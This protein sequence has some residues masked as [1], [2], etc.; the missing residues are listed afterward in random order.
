M[1][2]AAAAV[3]AL[4]VVA[5]SPAAGWAS[6]LEVRL[7]GFA[8]RAHSDLFTDDADLYT[9]DFRN[10]DCTATTCP[11]VRTRDWRGLYGGA[12]FSFNLD[13]HV[14]LGFSVDGYGRRIPTNYRTSVRDDG[15]EIQQDLRLTIV[16]VG[17]SL[18]LLPADKY[19][20]VQPYVTVGGD[21]FFYKYEEFGDFIDF[22]DDSRPIFHDSFR[23]QG[24]IFGGHAAAGLRVPLGHDFAVTGE[25]R[26]QF[27]PTKRM[28]DDFDQNRIDV[29]GGSAT[30]GVR[31]RF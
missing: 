11:G 13:P 22:F 30:L 1:S 19:A 28:N 23:S 10:R 15:S 21:V 8:P 26:Y 24:A 5:M 14:E 20:P 6:G 9:P 31:L 29:S 18:R 12:E 27:A 7:G 16:P 2:R 4:G 17:V 3:L 25:V